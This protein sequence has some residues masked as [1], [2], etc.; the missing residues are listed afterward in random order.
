LGLKYGTTHPSRRDQAIRK[1]WERKNDGRPPDTTKE[2]LK[3]IKKSPTK[4]S[5]T[6]KPPTTRSSIRKPPTA[7][8]SITKPPT[9]KS[10]ITK[11]PTIKLP[12]TKSSIRKSPIKESRAWL[13]IQKNL[14][15]DGI[16]LL[17]DHS[18]QS[19]PWNGIAS[20]WLD[21]SLEAL[22]FC[23]LHNPQKYEEIFGCLEVDNPLE[24]LVYH[25]STRLQ[26]Y[27]TTDTI[28]RLQ[29]DLVS[30]RDT[31]TTLIFLD[32]SQESNPLILIILNLN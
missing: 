32:I 17:T 20:C 27:D 7:K 15:Q 4:K 14:H 2:L 16:R 23:Y 18:Y 1:D 8:P 31:F 5:T 24:Q 10:S 19:Y 13:Y 3:S 11:P 22:F 12:T 28:P 9:A 30:L 29:E 25:M 21:A 26:Y 6:K